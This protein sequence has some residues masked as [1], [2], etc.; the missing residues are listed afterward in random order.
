L[1]PEEKARESIDGMLDA[2]PGVA[3]REFAL[4]HGFGE[5]D[6]FLFADEAGRWRYRSQKEG[7]ERHH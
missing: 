4:G 7:I 3:I 2:G 5:A 1:T 6:Y